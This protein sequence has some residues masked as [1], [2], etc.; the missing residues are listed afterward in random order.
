LQ[1]RTAL[2]FD[3][4]LSR[5]LG[6]PSR[7]QTV[8]RRDSAATMLQAME[9][10]NGDRLAELLTQAASHWIEQG[11][12]VETLFLTAYGRQPTPEEI[13]IAEGLLGDSPSV[14]EMADLLWAVVMQP[15]FQ[16][17]Q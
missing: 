7:D 17:I 12:N 16:L 8:T 3:G 11:A 5:A 1:V 4:P 2:L 14:E 15:E 10:T 6:R 9:L 13:R